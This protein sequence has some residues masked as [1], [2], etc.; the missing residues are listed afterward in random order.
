MIYDSR[1]IYSK[2]NSLTNRPFAQK[3]IELAEKFLITYVDKIIVS[4]PEDE[5]Y[6]KKHFMHNLK[7]SIIRNL[8]PKFNAENNGKLRE[9]YK[10][11]AENLLLLYQ[12]WILE[13]RGLDTVFE[14]MSK[15]ENTNLVLIGKGNYQEKLERKSK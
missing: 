10:I 6:L 9:K 14:S 15:L 11:P 8:P 13:G 1:E 4:A 2:L 12:G 3:Y 5:I 7:Y